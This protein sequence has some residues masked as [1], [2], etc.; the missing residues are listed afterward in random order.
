VEKLLSAER[1]TG[2]DQASRTVIDGWIVPDSPRARMQ[3]GLH[4][5]VPL[6]LG[7]LGDEGVG[8]IPLTDQL[9]DTTLR[10]RL[11]KRFRDQASRLYELYASERTQSPA[12]AERAI[13]ADLFFGLGMR[14]WADLQVANDSPVFFYHMAHVPPAFRLYDPDHPDLQLPLGPRSVGA[15][16]SGDLAFVFDNTHLV[17][18]DWNDDDRLT[19]KLM[20]DYWTTFARTGNPN[21]GSRPTW[22]AYDVTRRGT[23]VFDKGA[24]VVDGVRREKLDALQATLAG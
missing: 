8:L 3:A 15:Y 1:E 5:N 4:A 24:H 17:G 18:L 19:A 10:T 7:S 16:H 11:E 23:L 22:P 14:E 20:A 13:N 9:D 12:I 21:G 2:W 6:L